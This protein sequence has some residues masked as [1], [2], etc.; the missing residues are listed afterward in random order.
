M[1]KTRTP[2]TKWFTAM[3]LLSGDKRG[4]SALAISKSIGVA[5]FTRATA[6]TRE[7]L[8]LLALATT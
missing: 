3:F 8:I 1:D 5:Y 6:F 7:S 2:L 4:S